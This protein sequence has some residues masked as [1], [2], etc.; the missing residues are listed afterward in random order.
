MQATTAGLSVKL[1]FEFVCLTAVRSSKTRL[2]HFGAV[3]DN[4]WTIPAT[5]MKQGEPDRVRF[6][7]APWKCYRKRRRCRTVLVW[8]PVTYQPRQASVRNAV[9]NSLPDNG[10]D[11]TVHGIARRISHM[12]CRY[13]RIRSGG[14]G[15]TFAR[16]ECGSRCVSALRFAGT[17]ARTHAK[18]VGLPTRLTD[19]PQGQKKPAVVRRLF[20]REF[21]SDPQNR[22]RSYIPIGI[23]V[24]AFQETEG[25]RKSLGSDFPDR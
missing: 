2:W 5:R 16:Q 3:Q 23:Y 6:H 24:A 19:R 25:Q 10:I 21:R 9:S 8:H 17:A 20:V 1:L 12:G 7:G 22:R 4:V 14:F 13:R 15:R 18:L 11:G